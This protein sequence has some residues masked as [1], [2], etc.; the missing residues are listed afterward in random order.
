MR[1]RKDTR[2]MK[3][4][5]SKKLIFIAVLVALTVA[6]VFAYPLSAGFASAAEYGDVDSSALWYFGD[7]A[8]KVQSAKTVI[9]GWDKSKL[10]EK[11]IAVIDTGIDYKHELFDGVLYTNAEG[12]PVGYDARKKVEIP[13]DEMK[14]T[15]NDDKHGNAISGVVAMTVKELGLQD[16]IKIYPIKANT[17][18]K[19]G[20]EQKSFSVANV[21]E[22]IKQ[23][24][25]IGADA[26]NM[27]FGLLNN[28][29]DLEWAVNKELKDT[30]AMV[31]ENSLIVASAGNDGLNS[32]DG[33]RNLFYPACHDGVLSV[34]A[35]A[36]NGM[37][38]KSNYGSVY[39]VAG[40]GEDIYTAKYADGNTYQ[41]MEGTSLATPIACVTGALIKLRYEAEGKSVSSFELSRYMRNLDGRTVTKNGVEVRCIDFYTAV[42][43]DFENTQ[44]IYDDPTSLELTHNGEY[45]KDDYDD[46]IYQRAN[47]VSPV[48]FVAKINPFGNTDPGLDGAVQWIE[49]RQGKPDNI[50]GNGLRLAYTP[51]YIDETVTIIARLRF[52][53]TTFEQ[54]QEVYL[55][56]VDFYVGEA[57]VTYLGK[58]S[59]GV[60]NVPTSGVLYIT[61]T[62]VFSLTGIEYIGDKKKAKITWYVDGK[63]AGEGATFAYSPK[64]K[65]RHVISARYDGTPIPREFTATVKPA[66][67]RPLD[68]SMLIIGLAI[69][70]A[71][72]AVIIVIA[73]KRKRSKIHTQTEEEIV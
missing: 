36:R 13:L 35:Y 40:P 45:G 41:T 71:V 33:D 11:V 48:T 50:L 17:I 5:I 31:S 70:V 29:I 73:V 62:T 69:A 64:D 28:G 12:T 60:D 26:V 34:M 46:I 8:L 72:I 2:F 44:Y 63:I 55:S 59:Q 23:A 30:L 16:Y 3:Y 4:G 37:W 14:D 68:L 9:D 57:S 56:S 42:T 43:Q 15:A 39:D 65:G 47:A 10:R 22:A 49:Q 24:E 19:N 58:V 51:T 1:N 67:A 66:I 38:T 52:G 6:A 32:A 25:K 61:E 21:V 54:A 20:V 18:D 7:G 53:D 27:S